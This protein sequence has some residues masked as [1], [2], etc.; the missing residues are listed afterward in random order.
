MRSAPISGLLGGGVQLKEVD[1]WGH[2]FDEYT[3][4]LA[5][6]DHKL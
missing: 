6:K 4:C 5:I 2:T 3:L 1:Q